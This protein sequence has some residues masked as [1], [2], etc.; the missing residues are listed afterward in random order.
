MELIPDISN[1]HPVR[2]VI[3]TLSCV[4]VTFVGGCAVSGTGVQ[5]AGTPEATPTSTAARN[6]GLTPEAITVPKQPDAVVIT[7]VY[8]N[9]PYRT[10]L[11][12]SWGFSCVVEL[13]EATILFDTG[14]DGGV[15][16]HNM[17]KLD[18]DPLAMDLLVL[19]HIHTDHTGG[20]G[21][22]L[23]L[24]ARPMVY[25]PS[26]F[27]RSFKDQ[28]RA[29]TQVQEVSNPRKLMEGVYTTGEL[30]SGIIEQSLVLDTP[31]GLVVITGCSHPGI[32][33]IA[34]KAKDLYGGPLYLLMGGFHLGGKSGG[35]LERITSE[36]RGL[37]VRKVA[38]SHC[39][40]EEAIRMFARKWGDD[41]IP[42]GVGRVIE[43]AN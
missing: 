43:V 2:A 39:T 41:F 19:S 36:L 10:D 14:G 26:S 40:G 7:V 27:P 25:V 29:Q 24:G 4:A 33:N 6:L 22:V 21:S 31:Q 15:L 30:G 42:S 1:L 18:L 35:E 23:A 34:R 8:D 11:W 12:T 32:A 9:L 13:D 28:L 38:P 16:L 37:G 5:V 20:V 3:V 17:S